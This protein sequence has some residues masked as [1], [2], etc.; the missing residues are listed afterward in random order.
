MSIREIN[1]KMEEAI[2]DGD[3]NRAGLFALM[4]EEAESNEFA[5]AA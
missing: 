2:E 4:L 5:I 1:A 3:L